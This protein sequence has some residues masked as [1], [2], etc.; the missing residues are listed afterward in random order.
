MLWTS[1]YRALWRR[2]HA[3]AALG[4]PVKRRVCKPF[5]IFESAADISTRRK[6]GGAGQSR[7]FL[8]QAQGQKASIT[9][10]VRLK[11]FAPEM[12]IRASKNKVRGFRGAARPSLPKRPDLRPGRRRTQRPKG[13]FAAA[14]GGWAQGAE[15]PARR[16]A[17]PRLCGERAPAPDALTPRPGERK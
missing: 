16:L 10:R 13:S 2:R 9:M 17:L 14:P 5:Q 8:A 12:R 6:S 4:G 11:P 1:I 7:R 3:R 15:G